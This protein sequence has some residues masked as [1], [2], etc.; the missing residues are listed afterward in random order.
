MIVM[1]RLRSRP[2]SLIRMILGRT[3]IKTILIR[4]EASC[5]VAESSRKAVELIREATLVRAVVSLKVEEVMIMQA[6][7]NNAESQK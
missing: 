4:E 3:I 6:L 2:F 1:V 5:R 7:K